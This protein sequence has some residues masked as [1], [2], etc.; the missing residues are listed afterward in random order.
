MDVNKFSTLPPGTLAAQSTCYSLF[1]FSKR[2]TNIYWMNK[3][4]QVLSTG[5][6]CF[7][8]LQMV[9][10]V[11]AGRYGVMQM[12]PPLP[13][14]SI[15]DHLSALLTPP[16]T[17]PDPVLFHESL[18]IPPSTSWAESLYQ[19]WTGTFSSSLLTLSSPPQEDGATCNHRWR[20]SH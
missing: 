12:I 10:P 6:S 11:D 16:W 3:Y 20:F 4:L 17:L 5:M 1:S 9:L 14:I 2:S 8:Q 18:R 19:Q 15:P 13:S 7:S